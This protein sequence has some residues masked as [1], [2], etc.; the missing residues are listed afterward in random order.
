MSQSVDTNFDYLLDNYN[1]NVS[2][3]IKHDLDIWI[4]PNFDKYLGFD[5]KNIQT[6]LENNYPVRREGDKITWGE[7]QWVEGDNA[8]LK[9]RGNVLKR[10]KMWLQKGD[11]KTNGFVKYFYTGWQ[12]N[13]LPATACVDKCKELN[14]V[15]QKYDEWCMLNNYSCANH[16]IV[17]HYKDGS[18]NIGRHYDKPKSIQPQSLI[19]IIKTGECGRLFYLANRD[20]PDNPIFNSVVEPGTAIIMTLEANLKTVHA[21]PPVKTSGNSGS[22]VFRTITEVVPWDK[23]EKKVKN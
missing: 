9:Y 19:T 12:Y 14:D 13:V 22:I 8:A 23:L 5:A 10:G 6:E 3:K 17:T 20:D 11:P 18:H 21:V 4:I 15:W 16:A 1:L 2:F 7:C